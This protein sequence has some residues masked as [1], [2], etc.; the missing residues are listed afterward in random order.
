[1]PAQHTSRVR[2]RPV[3]LHVHASPPLARALRARLLIAPRQAV[4]EVRAFGI[5]AAQVDANVGAAVGIGGAVAG[6]RAAMKHVNRFGIHLLTGHRGNAAAVL[7]SSPAKRKLGLA[8][9]V[10]GRTGFSHAGVGFV[11]QIPIETAQF[12][13]KLATAV[14]AADEV[15]ART[16]A[17]PLPG[18]K[19]PHHLTSAHALFVADHGLGAADFAARFGRPVAI[20]GPVDTGLGGLAGRIA[21]ARDALSIQTN[22]VVTA[23]RPVGLCPSALALLLA[24][25][26]VAL[27]VTFAFGRGRVHAKWDRPT[28]HRARQERERRPPRGGIGQPARQRIEAIFVQRSLL[29]VFTWIGEGEPSQPCAGLPR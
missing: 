5:A 7:P 3:A 22:P 12:T 25:A 13:G 15:I 8:I 4:A 1:M 29:P 11:A 17:E 19:A 23:N 6:G 16:T 24:L 26:R 27:L 20:T 18:V 9:A 14:G 10:S 2:R 21:D 28:K